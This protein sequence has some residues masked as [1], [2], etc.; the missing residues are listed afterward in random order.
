[1]AHNRYTRKQILINPRLQWRL[2]R[3]ACLMPL[4]ALLGGSIVI[5]F[6]LNMVRAEARSLDVELPT[7]GDLGVAG[8]LFVGVCTVVIVYHGVMFSHRIAGP[9]FRFRKSFD[10][11]LGGNTKLKVHLRRNDYMHATAAHF[12]E[13]VAHIDE[14]EKELLKL[15]QLVALHQLEADVSEATQQDVEDVAPALVSEQTQDEVTTIE[16]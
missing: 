13:L 5:G 10:E 14:K 1:M 12:N 8:L 6:L 16:P 9:L 2:V 7:L 3:D 11:V 15:R 4:G